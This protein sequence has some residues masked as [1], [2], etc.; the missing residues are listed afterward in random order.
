LSH[1]FKANGTVRLS[2]ARIGLDIEC[3]GGQLA[4]PGNAALKADGIRI[5]GSLLITPTKAEAYELNGSKNISLN[6]PVFNATVYSMESFIPLIKLQVA[7][8]YAP[9]ANLGKVRTTPAFHCIPS[10]SVTD[11]SLLRYYLWFHIIA[12]WFLTT[13]WVGGLTGLI[14]R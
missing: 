4:N 14:R 8:S 3:F 9:N 1:N 7:D 11:G 12:G 2:R 5:E 13:L 6:Y 10:I